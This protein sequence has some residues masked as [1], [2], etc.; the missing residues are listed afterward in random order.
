MVLTNLKICSS[1]ITWCW[2]LI[3]SFFS[4]TDM[5][6]YLTHASVFDHHPHHLLKHHGEEVK[7]FCWVVISAEYQHGWNNSEKTLHNKYSTCWYVKGLFRFIR[8]W[9]QGRTCSSRGVNLSEVIYLCFTWQVQHLFFPLFW[10]T[11]FKPPVQ[12]LSVSP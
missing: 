8:P 5:L 12:P 7:V 10:W 2:L 3:K 9:L 1:K 6:C 4:K 11:D